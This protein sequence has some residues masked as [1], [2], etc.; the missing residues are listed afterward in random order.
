MTDDRPPPSLDELDARLD[1]A[2]ERQS[3]KADDRK[4]VRTSGLGFAMRIGVELVAALVV[5]V[6]IGILLDRWLGTTPWLMILFF[7][8]GAA[9]GILNLYRLVGG[10]GYAPG[11]GKKG[12]DERD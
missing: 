10:F 1:A 5:G 9:A 6:G 11:Y 4:T 2:R 12:T 8:L 3:D 7:V